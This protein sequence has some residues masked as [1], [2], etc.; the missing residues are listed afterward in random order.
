[1]PMELRPR[2]R[3][4][5]GHGQGSSDK[6]TAAVTMAGLYEGPRII[7]VWSVEDQYTFA[8]R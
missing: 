2:F 5:G 7:E 1:M 3:P 8:I 6:G 4:R